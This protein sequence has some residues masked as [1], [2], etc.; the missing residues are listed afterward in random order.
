MTRPWVV[1]VDDF[2]DDA[3]ARLGR[4]SAERSAAAAREYEAR[5]NGP[6]PR[7]TAPDAAIV[8]EAA[9]ETPEAR[10][11]DLTNRLRSGDRSVVDQLK[12]LLGL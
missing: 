10:I 9:V 12:R 7:E 3:A 6:R 8:P 11:A 1:V 5:L 2:A 4:E